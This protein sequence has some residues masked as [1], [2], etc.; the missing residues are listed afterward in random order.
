MTHMNYIYLAVFGYLPYAVVS[1]FAAGVA[2][3]LVGWLRPTSLTGLYNVNAT[4]NGYS[5]PRITAEILKR[6]FLFYTLTDA[7]PA[8]LIG[9]I[10]FHWG[11]WIAL[12]GHIGLLMTPSQLESIGISP[13]LHV[14]LARVIGGLGGVMALLG[15]LILIARRLVNI[16]VRVY[17][18]TVNV[19][20]RMFSYLDDY[21]AD[22]LLLAIIAL[23]LVQT[24]WLEYV[25]PGFFESTVAPW[26]WSLAS[27]NVGRAIGYIAGAPP[28]AQ[29]HVILAMVFIAY[30]PWGKMM[31]PFSLIYISPTVARPSIRIRV[32][33]IQGG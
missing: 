5:Y 28:V 17:G 25:E 13:G 20:L 16:R 31:H 11:I 10:L 15:I 22:A 33:S 18:F 19:P 9:S 30:F 27:L 24:L 14:T 8:L 23:G 4:V 29:A 7:D 3:R 2:F 21:F 6:I 26:I 12:I 32:R 1:I